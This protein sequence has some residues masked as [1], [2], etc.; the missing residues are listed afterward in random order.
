M[1]DQPNCVRRFCVDDLA[2]E[3]HL[4]RF[5]LADQSCQTLRATTA[6]NNPEI[7]LRLTK[8]RRFTRDANVASQRQLATASKT[9]TVDHCDNRASETCRSL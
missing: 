9:V 4:H 6:R 2:G 5:S 8:R 1:I 3:D 7:N